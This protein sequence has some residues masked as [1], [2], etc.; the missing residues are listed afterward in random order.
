MPIQVTCT[1][2]LTRFAV[3]DK[4]AGQTG[5]CPKCKHPIK[6]PTKKEEVVIHSAVEGPTDASGRPVLKPLEREETTLSPVIILS[7]IGACLVTLVLTYVIGNT[8]ADRPA[9]VPFYIRA[10]GAILLGPPLAYGCYSFLRNQELE[11]YRGLPLAIRSLICGLVYAMLWGVYSLLVQYLFSGQVETFHLFFLA[12]PIIAAGGVAA[13]ATLDLE[14]IAGV[15]HY[16]IYLA[17]TVLLR[18]LMGIPPI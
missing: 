13:L 15:I 8:F 12:P 11:P 3:S 9:G 4:F 18:Y 10:M 17:V 2:C 6:I 5:P 1:N 16:G 7:T 14:F